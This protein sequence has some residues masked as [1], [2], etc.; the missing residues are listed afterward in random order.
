MLD[1]HSIIAKAGTG[2]GLA[3]DVGVLGNSA[4]SPR[5]RECGLRT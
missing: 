3:D 5:M 1:A 2:V 4:K